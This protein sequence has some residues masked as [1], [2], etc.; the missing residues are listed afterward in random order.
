MTLL[1]TV[2]GPAA[3]ALPGVLTGPR[4][5]SHLLQL[6]QHQAAAW[7]PESSDS[8]WLT[9][10]LRLGSGDHSGPLFL[11]DRQLPTLTPDGCTGCHWS[12]HLSA[13]GPE[14][15]GLQAAGAA[16][17]RYSCTATV[18]CGCSCCMATWNPPAA[19]I[20]WLSSCLVTSLVKSPLV[21]PTEFLAY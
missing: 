4:G 14:T 1:V 11:A 13:P 7:Q 10:H 12:S 2:T 3:P 8:A 18:Q 17:P 16:G 9:Q 20:Q 15:E 21:W 6:L 19:K 5:G